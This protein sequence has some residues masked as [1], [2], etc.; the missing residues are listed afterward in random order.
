MS[1]TVC[2]SPPA[3][4]G[5]IWPIRAHT[6]YHVYDDFHAPGRPLD[7]TTV[8]YEQD[9]ADLCTDIAAVRAEADVVNGQFHWGE[10]NRPA[11]LLGYER[12]IAHAAID[13]GM[14]VVLGLSV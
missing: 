12:A 7:I 8:P 5:A 6:I 9:L 1:C 11:V 10:A 14:D 3:V 2:L 4:S 13:A